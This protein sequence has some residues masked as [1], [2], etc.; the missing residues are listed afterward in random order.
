MDW[1]VKYVAATV[2]Y[3]QARLTACF[4]LAAVTGFAWQ[5]ISF[6]AAE[7]NTNLTRL[8]R[9]FVR[10]AKGEIVFSDRDLEIMKEFCRKAEIGLS[11]ATDK[12]AQSAVNLKPE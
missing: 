7:T 10:A 1:I 4:Q 2:E 6:W 9:R 3:E 8:E 12:T 5:A 11:Y